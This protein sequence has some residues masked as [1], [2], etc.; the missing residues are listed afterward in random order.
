MKKTL[1]KL[2]TVTVIFFVS[3]CNFAKKTDDEEKNDSDLSTFVPPNTKVVNNREDNSPSD[4]QATNNIFDSTGNLLLTPE[5]VSRTMLLALDY[6]DGWTDEIFGFNDRILRL[7]SV[8]LGGVDFVTN[9]V[10]ER[11][12]KVQTH[13]VI[14]MVAWQTAAGIVWREG[15]DNHPDPKTLFTL[16]NINEDRPYRAETDDA[17]GSQWVLSVKEGEQRWQD[18]L[19]DLY[20]RL[21]SRPPTEPEIALIKNAFLNAMDQYNGWIAGAWIPVIYALLSS[22][23][24]WNL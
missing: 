12:P 14:R 16:S 17:G 21:L 5:Q 11:N 7:L 23:E 22:T 19:T 3:F 24:F 15:S 2:L 9:S 6:K 18:Q 4:S 1:N 8:P 20:W 10:R 13:L